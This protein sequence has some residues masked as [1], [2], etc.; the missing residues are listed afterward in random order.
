MKYLLCGVRDRKVEYCLPPFTARNEQDAVR[1]FLELL[2]DDE[3]SVAHH[4]ADFELLII[5]S[6]D[7]VTMVIEGEASRRFVVNG[8]DLLARYE[9]ETRRREPPLFGDFY[10]QEGDENG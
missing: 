1:V 5:G 2:Q 3:L 4:P 8:A 7:D 10:N 9:R 6:F